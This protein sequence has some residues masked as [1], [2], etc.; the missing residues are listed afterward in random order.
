MKHKKPYVSPLMTTIIINGG[1]YILAGSSIGISNEQATTTE[2]I[3]NEK[4][5]ESLSRKNDIWEDE[6]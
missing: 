5:Y 1:T 6:E 4:W 2:T 3:N